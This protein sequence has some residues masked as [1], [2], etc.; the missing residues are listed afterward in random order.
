MTFIPCS[1]HC[2][3]RSSDSH[4]K[5]TSKF[6]FQEATIQ[7]ENAYRTSIQSIQLYGHINI[8]IHKQVVVQN[9]GT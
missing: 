7:T 4:P 2:S 9:S 1:S 8:N 5:K 6:P 3:R